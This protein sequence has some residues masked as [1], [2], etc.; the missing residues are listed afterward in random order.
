MKKRDRRIV[1]IILSAVIVFIIGGIS[2]TVK[3]RENVPEDSSEYMDMLEDEYR[4]D[5]EGILSSEGIRNAGINLTKITHADGS[6]DYS[7]KIYHKAFGEEETA[8]RIES[9]ISAVIF[10]HENVNVG[11]SLLEI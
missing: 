11:I 10:P 7:L 9:A 4:T 2:L 3:G 8:Y 5:I 1:R 6:R